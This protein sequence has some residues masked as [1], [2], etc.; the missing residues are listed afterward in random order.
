MLDY[1]GQIS[2]VV[3]CQGCSL[4]CPYCHNKEFQEFKNGNVAE[5]DFL[6]FLRRRQG[7][8]DAIVFSG[9]EPIL[10]HDIR[11]KII[12]TKKMGYLIGLHTSG[13]DHKALQS[14]IDLVD[15]VGFDFKTIFEK[16]HLV[17]KNEDAGGMV[18]E[19]LGLLINNGINFEVRTTY[20][21]DIVTE[22]DLPVMANVLKKNGINKWFLQRCIL[23]YENKDE[24]VIPLPDRIVIDELSEIVEVELRI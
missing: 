4:R 23:R 3:F 8:L 24:V 16:Y 19:S 11:E 21:N 18:F 15:W 5:E 14:V 20:D 12:I 13:I 7:A 1:P 9:G 10:Q 17:A 6:D 2:A 22:E